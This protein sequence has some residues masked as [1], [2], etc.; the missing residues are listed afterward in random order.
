MLKRKMLIF[1][2]L[3]AMLVLGGVGL[4]SASGHKGQ[5]PPASPQG[6][7]KEV[8][9]LYNTTAPQGIYSQAFNGPQIT[10]FGNA[11]NLAQ[12][13]AGASLSTVTVTMVNFGPTAFTTP[14]TFSIYQLGTGGVVGGLVATDNANI[15]VPAG[16]TGPVAFNATFSFAFQHVVL[17]STIVYGI[18]LDQLITDCATTPGDCGND[19]NPIGSLN[20]ALSENVSAGTDVYPGDVYVSSLQADASSTALGSNLGYCTGAPAGVLSTFQGVP[21]MCPVGCGSNIDGLGVD[22]VPA[23]LFVAAS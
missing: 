22:S 9:A 3:V 4:A 17:P 1:A 21:V 7:L 20:V 16:T 14:I 5:Y 2:A 6:P 11:V 12:G 8:I 19:P 18:T 15:A 10:E 23:V 13:T